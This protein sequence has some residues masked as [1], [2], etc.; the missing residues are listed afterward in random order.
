MSHSSIFINNLVTLF[1]VITHSEGKLEPSYPYSKGFVFVHENSE[2]LQRTHH[3]QQFLFTRSV[4]LLCG[5]HYPLSCRYSIDITLGVLLFQGSADRLGAG[6][7]IYE[8]RQSVNRLSNGLYSKFSSQC[9]KF[10][11]FFKRLFPF[12]SSF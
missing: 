4:T 10:E 9:L 6:I 8:I 11:L 2:F 5:I 7:C 12:S 1:D 3:G